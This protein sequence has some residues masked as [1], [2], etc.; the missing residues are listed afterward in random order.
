VLSVILGL[1]VLETV[2]TNIVNVL[3]LT[4]NCLGGIYYAYIKYY[5]SKMKVKFSNGIIGNNN[6]T[7]NSNGNVQSNDAITV[8]VIPNSKL[9]QS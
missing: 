4:L 8:S 7:I 1:F 6:N 3:G 5:E 9:I 2:E